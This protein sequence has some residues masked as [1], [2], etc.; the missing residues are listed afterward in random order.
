MKKGGVEEEQ[1]ELIFSTDDENDEKKNNNHVTGNDNKGLGLRTTGFKDFFLRPELLRAIGEAGFEHP[2]EVQQEAIP[3]AILGNDLVCQAKSGMGKTAVFVLSILHQLDFDGDKPQCLVLCHTR[4]LAFQITKEFER[5]GKYFLN[6]KTETLYGGVPVT[7]QREKLSQDCPHVAVGTPGRVLDLVKS[8][9]L[10]LDKI[11]FFVL[12]ECDKM[13]EQCDMREDVQEIF[14]KT[15][16]NKQVTMFSATMTEESRGI[17]KKFMRTPME[18]F[19]DDQKKLTLHG[20]VQYYCKLEEKQKTKTLLGLLYKLNYNQTII[21]CK[22]I[23]RA[24]FL[25]EILE[26]MDLPSIAIHR[27]MS[28]EERIEKYKEFKEFKKRILVAT[29]IISRGIDIERVNV[30]FNYD[31]PDDTDTYLHRVGRAGRFG[32]KGLSI[33]FVANDEENKVLTDIQERFA[34]KIPELPE[35]IDQTLY[36]NN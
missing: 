18:I 10:K 31:M 16:H 17:C 7:A 4:E 28:Q 12:D 26:K 8:G 30:V 1:P 6:L 14:I 15:R 21:F 33:T 25:N 13:L 34:I 35:T 11:R 36:R 3:Y 22:T 24:K 20:L 23:E 27:R 32:T 19:I 2:S 5:L 9:H 29:N